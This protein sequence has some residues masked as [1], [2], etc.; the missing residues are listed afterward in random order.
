MTEAHIVA[1]K[2]F[3][4]GGIPVTDVDNLLLMSW[5]HPDIIA[6]YHDENSA[7]GFRGPQRKTHGLQWL[8][9]VKQISIFFSANFWRI[10]METSAGR[11]KPLALR[12]VS[13]Y[14][15]PRS[16]TGNK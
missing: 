3:I 11:W 4:F 5:P 10:P 14:T 13:R 15:V 12:K 1:A 8:A 9:D 6:Q 7:M 16:K 2:R